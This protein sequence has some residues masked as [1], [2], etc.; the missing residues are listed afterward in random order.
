GVESVGLTRVL[1]PGGGLSVPFRVIGGRGLPD[2]S[3]AQ[4]HEVN[5]AFFQAMRVPLLRGRV[6][7]ARDSETA[8]G[9]VLINE[10]FARRF[11]PV[12]DPLGQSIQ[13]NLTA[14]N[15]ALQQDRVREVVGVVGDVR[16]DFRAEFVP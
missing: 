12:G 11:F 4:Y 6:F 2:D 1:P 9:V 5:A 3:A 7:S 8:P 15:P 10:T 14:A 13:T 16:M